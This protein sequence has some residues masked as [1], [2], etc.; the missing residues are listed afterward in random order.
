MMLRRP[1]TDQERASTLSKIAEGAEKLRD[2]ARLADQ[3]FL[4]F[5]LENVIEEARS[6][7]AESLTQTSEGCQRR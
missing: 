2:L 7:R 6:A 4:A 5:L 1:L 3:G